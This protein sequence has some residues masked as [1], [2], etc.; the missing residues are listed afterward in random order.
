MTQ[1]N[2]NTYLRGSEWRKWDL[3]IHTPLSIC[4]SYGGDSEFEDFIIALEKLPQDIKVVGINDYYFIDGYEKVMGY[5]NQGRLKNLEKIIPILEFRI[6]TFGNASVN[7]F[8]KINLHVV[9]NVDELLINDEVKKI[10]EEFINQIKLSH[11]HDTEI[12]S[13]NNL[14]KYSSNKDLQTG[15]S[16][17]V[18][19]TKEVIDLLNK[20]T[21]RDKTLKF[22]GYIEWNNLNKSDQLK[23][24]KK[25]LYNYADAF[26]TASL[27]DDFS[28]K[29]EVLHNFG[30]VKPLLHS[31][32]IHRFDQ[33][34][35]NNY[36]CQTWIKADPTFEGLK[37]ILY[38]PDRI[39]LQELRP[40]EKPNYH[41]IDRIEYK[42]SDNKKQIIYFNQN[43]NSLIGSRAT[44]KSNILKNISFA[45]DYKQTIGKKC[46]DLFHLK[47]FRLIW[48]DKKINTLNTSVEKEKGI[49]LIPQGFLGNIV[50]EKDSQFYNF[51]FELFQNNNEFKSVID[52]YR[53]FEDKNSLKISDNIKTIFSI[54]NEGRNKEALLKKYG[55]QEDIKKE[56]LGI[57]KQIKN[58]NK[59]YTK[60]SVDE[61]NKYNQFIDLRN[62]N[63]KKVEQIEKDYDVLSL[64][65]DEEIITAEKL[66]KFELSQLYLEKILKILKKSD[67]AFKKEFIDVELKKLNE[68]KIKINKEI[69]KIINELI[70]LKRKV[71][72]HKALLELTQ[73]LQLTKEK[74]KTVIVLTEEIKQL[75]KLY[76]EKIN[77]LI[78]NYFNFHEEYKNVKVHFENLR[79]SKV[80]L[81]DS[82][83]EGGFKNFIEENINYHNSL[84]FKQE[85]TKEYAEALNFF[86]SFGEW[87]YQTGSFKKALFQIIKSVLKG[88]LQ[89]KSG[90]QEEDV[91]DGLLKNR[92]KINF[93]NSIT[94]SDNRNFDNMSDGEK[95]ILLLEF[96]FEFDNFS[97]PVL[98]DQP[99]DDL[100]VKAVSQ[101]V[102]FLV[103]Q[104]QER[105]IVMVSHNA[106]LVVCA[107]SEELIVA[108]KV[109][110]NKTQIFSYSTGSIENKGKTKEIIEILEGGKDALIKRVKK[111]N[112][113]INK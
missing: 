57:D 101:V 82:F 5:K 2:Q 75:S 62:T 107:D 55:K 66:F 21:W 93:R 19:S 74:L 53:K 97:Y 7:D 12:L 98:L 43:L 22:L 84:S 29:E 95:V 76:S 73:K 47:D 67:E 85:N 80:N 35:V 28:K 45:A 23:N 105:Q 103:K 14:I 25:S 63:K 54:R 48:L 38:E 32:D 17:F 89:I 71:E 92:F 109:I 61:L 87:K 88:I 113:R 59:S 94:T 46:D 78:E 8:Q 6:D 24:E 20:K 77:D 34:S 27:T 9:F 83:E 51:V 33:L 44:G 79:F 58:I 11:T 30:K 40:E 56:I 13:K 81:I 110:N 50:Y 104:K 64:L 70:P 91:I 26:F 69:T 60:I 41:I 90:K 99:E 3:H 1:I 106:N 18:P 39:R 108:N 86:Q 36:K 16:E 10:R 52:Q 49:L 65:R 102:E 4:Q 42:N 96:I 15:F 31:L 37:Q 112:I 68:N 100:D 111:L 72:K